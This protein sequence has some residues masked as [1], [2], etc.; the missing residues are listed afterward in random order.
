MNIS[1]SRKMKI[2]Q[3]IDALSKLSCVDKDANWLL[4]FETQFLSIAGDDRQIDFE[5][6]RKALHLSQSSFFASRFFSI[7]DKDGNGF[8]SLNEMI[9]GVTLLMNGTQLDKLKFLFQVYDVDGDGSIDYDELRIMLKSCVSESSLSID[10]ENL[11]TLTNTF[12]DFADADNNGSI[13]FEELKNVFDKY[14]DII[15]NLTISSANWL[16]P[17]KLRQ[18]KKP[19]EKFWPFWLSWKHIKNYWSYF[20]FLSVFFMINTVL[21]VEA[22]IRYRESMFLVSIAR[23]AGACLNFSPVVVLILMYRHI[24]TLIRST[25]LSF[26]F[27]LDKFIKLHKIVGYTIIVLSLVHFLAHLANFSFIEINDSINSNSSMV[28]YLFGVGT[29]GWVYGSAGLTGLLLLIILI[30]MFICSL[31]VVRRKGKFEVFYWSHCLYIIWYIV[32]ILHGPHFWKWFVGP[33]IVFIIEKIFRSKLFHII[34]YGRTFIEEVNLLPSK[35][36]HLSITR[37]PNFNYQPGDYVFIQIPSITR[38][39]W[40]PFTISSAPEMSDVFWLHIRGVGSWT[41]E[42]YEHFN[43]AYND[44]YT[45][46]TP[47]F[48]GNTVDSL[49]RRLGT[50]VHRRFSFKGREKIQ[51]QDERQPSTHTIRKYGGKY[52]CKSFFCDSRFEVHIDGPYGTPSSAIFQS[53]HAVLISSG[54]GVTPFASILQSIMN[55]FKLSKQKCPHC[56]HSW[57]GEIP[58][59]ILN[60]KKVDFIWINRDQRHFEWFMELLNELEMEQNE[61]GTLMDRFF[62]MHM[63]ITSALQRTDVKALG[64]QMALDLIHKEKNIDLITGLKTRT[65]TGRPNWDKIFKELKEN[66]Y[67]PVTVFYCGSPVL[68]RVLSVKSQYYGFKF[69]KENF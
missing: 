37:P 7:F 67:G 1:G 38:Y 28:Q 53:E 12:F 16:K 49:P 65:Q 26:L 11:D 2:P 42:L 5:G 24:A 35:V 62:D 27:P 48:T 15:D 13:S 41:N 45:T 34:H 56:S 57:T 22:A 6:F 30:I 36:T 63:Y 59:T 18:D 9:N 43:N 39:E 51:S 69:R 3:I 29:I 33:A 64:L 32:L 44:K 46:G 31:P 50:L 66:G 21:F 47:T 19:F 60:L 8:I 14:P 40:H 17:Q 10:E 52:T 55:R 20:I 23:G 54:I 58:S 4:W 25:R 61:Y 68:A